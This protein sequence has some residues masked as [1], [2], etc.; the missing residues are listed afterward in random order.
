M[1]EKYVNKPSY[2]MKTIQMCFV[3]YFIY[4]FTSNSTF[5]YRNIIVTRE[6]EKNAIILKQYFILNKMTTYGSEEKIISSTHKIKK[7][8]EKET[9]WSTSK[10]SKR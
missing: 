1:V 2:E 4:I 8:E 9:V 10:L 6:D 7:K 5:R 3:F